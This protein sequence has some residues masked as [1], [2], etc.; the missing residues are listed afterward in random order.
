MPRLRMKGIRGELRAPDVCP[1]GGG[2][3]LESVSLAQDL[4]ID[5]GEVS[6]LVR[7]AFRASLPSSGLL[8]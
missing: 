1:R 7:N 3:L 8:R 6:V 2:R 5:Q 4:A